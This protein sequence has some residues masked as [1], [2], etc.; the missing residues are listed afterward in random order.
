VARKGAEVKA[1]FVVSMVDPVDESN[2]IVH[3]SDEGGARRVSP[4]VDRLDGLFEVLRERVETARKV[5]AWLRAP[6]NRSE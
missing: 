1:G 2:S 3:V 4:S 6:P 5:R